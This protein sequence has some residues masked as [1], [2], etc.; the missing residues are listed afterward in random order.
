M[1]WRSPVAGGWRCSGALQSQNH[2]DAV[3]Q[4]S[5][6]RME[7]QRNGVAQSQED[8]D[9]VAQSSSRRM[10]MQWHT[11]VVDRRG[12]I[13][14]EPAL[15]RQSYCGPRTQSHLESAVWFQHVLLTTHSVL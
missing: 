12:R 8:G 14:S 13:R 6:R 10:E 2:G 4:Y 1:Q 15:F 5:S 3:A 11:P 7:M 9:A